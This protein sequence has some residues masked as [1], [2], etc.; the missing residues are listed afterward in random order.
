[1]VKVKP[2]IMAGPALPIKFF[3]IYKINAL[4]FFEVHGTVIAE[5]YG[6]TEKDGVKAVLL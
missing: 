3:L 5:C 1:V 4:K 6:R 2:Y